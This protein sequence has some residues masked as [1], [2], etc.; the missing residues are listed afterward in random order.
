M[1][2]VQGRHQGGGLKRFFA[3]FLPFSFKSE[4]AFQSWSPKDR[5]SLLFDLSHPAEQKALENAIRTALRHSD[6]AQAEELIHSMLRS[7]HSK[8]IPMGLQML[9]QRDEKDALRL[10]D[11]LE[12][13]QAR[14][15]RLPVLVASF[16]TLTQVI[17]NCSED[18]VPDLACFVAN[19]A[20][21]DRPA[22]IVHLLSTV[23]AA[24][25][26][27][28]RCLLLEV[29]ELQHRPGPARTRLCRALEASLGH[30]PDSCPDEA[31]FSTILIR[32]GDLSR[33]AA[34]SVQ[35]EGLNLAALEAPVRL[36]MQ[37]SVR[38][39]R[40][41]AIRKQLIRL[42]ECPLLG[43]P[44]LE[45]LESA[46]PA[47]LTS[48]LK[49]SGHLL[50][51]PSLRRHLIGSRVPARLAGLLRK[52]AS[53]D[54]VLLRQAPGILF[55][56]HDDEEI[57]ASRLGVLGTCGDPMTRSVARGYL[58]RMAPSAAQTRALRCL[59]RSEPSTARPAAAARWR[60]SLQQLESGLDSLSP[61][62]AAACSVLHH[63]ERPDAL[64]SMLRRVLNTGTV[65]SICSALEII[66][67]RELAADFES[68][69]LMLS[70]PRSCQHGDEVR[71]RALRLLA[72]GTSSESARA[73]LRGLAD[74]SPSVQQSAL[75]AATSVSGSESVKLGCHVIDR[76]LL[77][78]LAR[79]S[80]TRIR[81]VALRALQSRDPVAFMALVESLF[82]S[83]SIRERLAALEGARLS[84]D[85]ALSSRVLRLLEGSSDPGVHETGRI[86]LRSLR[87]SQL[88]A[89]TS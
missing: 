45:A 11:D 86:A 32:A 13:V 9:R 53:V 56:C 84:G 82:D 62:E 27:L 41:K 38:N 26:L 76:A 77:E 4:R 19:Q 89:S 44:A 15:A 51:S 21:S 61:W 5:F 72:S 1:A 67:R 34:S 65:T 40:S 31:I 22:L 42:L 7:D 3:Q 28:H 2:K 54:P 46:R 35:G 83:P 6:E 69:L 8:A 24:A 60:P 23:P 39:V 64:A 74:P 18:L 57:V 20:T 17:S 29:L 33:P 59:Q 80:D 52:T 63:R 78:R 48:I 16:E 81:R 73:I 70:G 43:E 37:R 12:L 50:A 75:E 85:G 58:Q 25:P 47:V 87:A 88:G 30:T 71:S 79:T 55:D 36:L 49:E 10:D 14:R 68:E 66:D